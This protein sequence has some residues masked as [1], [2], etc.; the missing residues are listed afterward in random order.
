[1]RSQDQLLTTKLYIPPARSDLV[2]RSRLTQQLDK[3]MTRK[4][5]LISAPAGFGKTTLLSEWHSSPPGNKWPLAWVSL[6]EGDND[7]ARFWAYVIAALQTLQPDLGK[8]TL[9]L[10]QAGPDYPSSLESMLTLLINQIMTS[11]IASEGDFALVLDDY[12][13]L[14][15]DIIHNGLTFLLDNLPPQ[16]HLI[17]ASRIDPPLPLARLRARHQLIELREADL[18]FTA[19]EATMFLNKVMGLNLSTDNIAALEAHTEGWVA[20][21]QLAAIS[22]QGQASISDF[23]GSHHYVLDYLTE[24]VLYRQPENV[25]NFLLQTSI[26]ERLCGSLCDAVTGQDNSAAM[27][28]TL[29]QANLFITPID[30]YR[31]WYRYHHLFADLLRHQLNQ[32]QGKQVAELHRRAAAWYASEGFTQGAVDHALAARDFEYAGDLIEKVYKNMFTRGEVVALLTWLASFP[33]EQIRTRPQLCLIQAWALFF[34]GKLDAAEQWV[35]EAVDKLEIS[36]DDLPKANEVANP[37]THNLLSQMMA[38]LAQISLIHGDIAQAVALSHQAL[39]ELPDDEA[40]LRG[41]VAL[42]LGTAYWVQGDVEAANRAMAEVRAISRASD[43]V[44]ALL[45]TTNLAEIRRIQGH[46]NQ[47]ELLYR[48]ALQL[49]AESNEPLLPTIVGLAHVGLGHV[50]YEWNELEPATRHL[51]QG[52]EL[53]QQGASGRVLTTGYVG[54]SRVFQAQ[55]KWNEAM[56][57]IQQAKRLAQGLELSLIQAWIS[58]M[59]ARLWIA[60]GNLRAAAQWARETELTLGDKIDNL[61]EFEDITLVRLQMAEGKTVES[62]EFLKRLQQKVQETGRTRSIIEVLILQALAYQSQQLLPAPSGQKA[63]LEALSSYDKEGMKALEQALLLAE[64]EGYI[65]LFADEGSPMAALLLQFTETRQTQ[66]AVKQQSAP[67]YLNKLL[68]SLG[69]DALVPSSPAY[70]DSQPLVDPLSERE[71]EVLQLI[72]AGLTNQEILEK[73]VIARGTLKTHI[74]NIYRKLA[75]NS[76]LQAV[77]KAKA[78]KLL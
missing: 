38:L 65:R 61:R 43:H 40:A 27:L 73:L 66:P 2:P 78:L 50:L 39:E 33:P 19:D 49:T 51:K 29:A 36:I 14:E 6:A 3:G 72:A 68:A 9:D 12:Q 64:P 41:M 21:L 56:E 11:S 34:R 70:Q 71:F 77:T 55:G 47:A 74:R 44:T 13:V 52:I 20:G 62:I 53:G 26:L 25:Q 28:K 15:S 63:N 37:E 23:I 75:V 67:A 69:V 76:R 42:N 22:L 5:T 57:M 18:R 8:D 54:L 1:M 35:Q 46:L 45:T 7:P 60:Q 59:Q 17:I 4:L 30:E 32:T 58:T 16:M 10:L 31:N 24:E 48:R